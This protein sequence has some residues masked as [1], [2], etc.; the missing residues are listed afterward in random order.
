MLQGKLPVFQVVQS[1]G[2]LDLLLLLLKLGV[3]LRLQLVQT[4]ICI[5]PLNDGLFIMLRRA[6]LNP[7]EIN[8][9]I[10]RNSNR[11]ER[12]CCNCYMVLEVLMVYFNY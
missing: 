8:Q 3:M 12:C 10:Y 1:S 7:L 4:I 5:V 11:F 2:V 6:V 9:M